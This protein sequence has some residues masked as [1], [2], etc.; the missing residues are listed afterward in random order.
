MG[1][2]SVPHVHHPWWIYEG[3]PPVMDA[4][5]SWGGKIW[6]GSL[7]MSLLDEVSSNRD[8]SCRFLS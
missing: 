6:L 7:S 4:D 3:P 8:H 1:V 2:R 5:P